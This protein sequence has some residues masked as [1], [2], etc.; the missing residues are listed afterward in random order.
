MNRNR[1][2]FMGLGIVAVGAVGYVIFKRLA[3]KKKYTM[4]DLPVVPPVAGSSPTAPPKAEWSPQPAAQALY[5]SM[6]GVGT[7][8]DMFFNTAEPLS[9]NQRT[10]VK[11]YFNQN[12]G[13]GEDLCNWI[14]GDFS[15]GSET[16]ALALFGYPTGS[17]WSNCS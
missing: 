16:K 6:K 9:A 2:I 5:D 10:A 1:V 8:E 17:W 12:L 13:E 7:D 11:N 15:W 4:A 3:N 14:E